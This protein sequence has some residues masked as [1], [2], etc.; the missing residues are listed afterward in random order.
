MCRC[1][2]QS[3]RPSL[4]FPEEAGQIAYN[5]FIFFPTDDR[6]LDCGLILKGDNA[7]L[8]HQQYWYAGAWI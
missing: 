3:P 6:D 5:I 4:D 1:C 7:G 8:A 2:Q